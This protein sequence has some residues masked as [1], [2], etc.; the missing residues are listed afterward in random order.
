MKNIKRTILIGFIIMFALMSV[1]CS[2]KEETGIDNELIKD[3]SFELEVIN[4]EDV[5]IITE[6]NIDE[7]GLVEI[8]AIFK[9]RDGSEEENNWIGMNLKDVLDFAGVED[10]DSIEVEALDGFSAEYTPQIVEDEGTII[11]LIKDDELLDEESGPIQTVVKE[12][13]SNM[14]IKEVVKLKVK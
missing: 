1:A 12:E 9:M 13:R 11:G 5:I 7:I 2:S 14:W 6:E 3:V 8:D 10:Y 4:D